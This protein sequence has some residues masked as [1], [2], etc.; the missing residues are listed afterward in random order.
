[1]LTKGDV[2]DDADDDDKVR[3]SVTQN[4][5]RSTGSEEFFLRTHLISAERFGGVL[6]TRLLNLY[7]LWL[8]K[9]NKA[10]IFFSGNKQLIG[11]WILG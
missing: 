8:R 11:M 10:D 7:S 1:M 4:H 9:T 3:T 6:R 5:A 2:D